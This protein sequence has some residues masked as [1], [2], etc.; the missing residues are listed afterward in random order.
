MAEQQRRIFEMHPD[1][2]EFIVERRR[3]ILEKF[4]RVAQGDG[5]HTVQH[6]RMHIMFDDD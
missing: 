6:R 3:K 1:P 4:D 5:F 2:R